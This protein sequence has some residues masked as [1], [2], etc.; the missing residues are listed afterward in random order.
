MQL[1]N[2][3]NQDFMFVRFVLEEQSLK[4]S[5]WGLL[6]AGSTQ[7]PPNWRGQLP[8]V[9]LVCQVDIMVKLPLSHGV[10]ARPET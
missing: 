2:Q 7:E 3:A 6:L 5:L 10:A 4:T 9:R 1:E 8:S